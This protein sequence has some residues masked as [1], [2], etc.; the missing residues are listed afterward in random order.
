[1]R[2]RTEDIKPLSLFCVD[3]IAER[4]GQPGKGFDKQFSDMLKAYPWPGNVRE[5]LNVLETAYV[6]ADYGEVLYPQHLP[7]YVRI[8]VTKASLGSG[9]SQAEPV[10]H[11]ASSHHHPG[12]AMT[13]TS[14]KD[15]KDS[16]EAAYL[17]KLLSET[18]RDVEAMLD[19]SGLSKSHL[20]ALLKKH[21]LSLKTGIRQAS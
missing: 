5:L 3:Q 4:Y 20:Y 9:P 14:F 6:A 1:L 11:D 13:S 12:D 15:Y 16:M 7:S 10:V 18:D 21:G 8:A 2:E 19:I 17:S